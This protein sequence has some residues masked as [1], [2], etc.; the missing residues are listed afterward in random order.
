MNQY[1]AWVM[2]MVMYKIEIENWRKVKMLKLKMYKLTGILNF[3]IE[4]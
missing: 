4:N 3:P 1:N 2:E